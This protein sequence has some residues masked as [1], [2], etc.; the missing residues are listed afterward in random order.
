MRDDR[1]MVLDYKTDRPPPDDPTDVPPVYLRQMAVY[2]SALRAVFP[3]RTVECLLLWTEAPKMMPL[4]D[5]LLDRFA[6]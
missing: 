1:V 5:V 6:P 4:A 3:D 2:R